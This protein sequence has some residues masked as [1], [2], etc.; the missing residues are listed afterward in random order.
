[1]PARCPI[2]AAHFYGWRPVGDIAAQVLQEVAF[3]RK[4]RHLVA[5]GPRVVGE[6]LAE[7]AAE[8]NLGTVINDALDRY[9]K[10]PDAALDATNGRNFPPSPLHEVEP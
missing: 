4:V 10:I 7:I 8:R 3:R 5:K 1:M 2:I 9:I 6:L